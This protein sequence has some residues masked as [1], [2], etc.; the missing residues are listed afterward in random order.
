LHSRE[1]ELRLLGIALARRLDPAALEVELRALARRSDRATR[2]ALA[3][4]LAAAPGPWA[5]QF[6]EHCLTGEIEEELELALLAMLIRR[7]PLQPEHM[8]RVLGARDPTVMA[9]AHVVAKGPGAWPQIEPLVPTPGVASDLVDAIV[10]AGRN[11]CAPLLLACLETAGPEQQHRALVMLNAAARPPHGAPSELLRLLARRGDAAVRAEAVLALSRTMPRSAALRQ[12]VAA[13]D[14]PSFRVRRRA[15]QALC[16]HGERATA[17]LRH[18]LGTVTMASME[19]VWALAAIGSPPARRLLAAYVRELRHDA[20]RAARLREEIAAAPDRARWAAL[21][22]CLRDHHGRIIDVVLAALAPALEARLTRRL[23]HVLQGADQ[24]HRASAFELVAAGPASRLVPG[25]VDLLRYLLFEHSTGAGRLAGSGADNLLDQAGASMS[26]WVRRAAA[27]MAAC[28]SPPRPVLP[29]ARGAGS[30]DR[31]PA[32]ERTMESDDQEFE[33]VVAL[34]RTPLFRYV[35]FETLLEVARSVQ[36][37]LYLT[38]EQV[39]AG[40][41]GGQDLLI[42]EAGVLMVGQGDGA[43]TLTA[44]ACF[45][46]VAVAGEPMRW[47]RITA[48]EDARVSLLRA[49]IFQELCREHP[50]M[51][52]E[53]CRL[54]ARRLRE[55]GAADAH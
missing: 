11:D 2:T 34:K 8:A 45:G 28:P 55:A 23:R 7:T 4:L 18:R 3:P 51:A 14:D 1:P 52:L 6:V 47:P 9:L 48:V 43:R 53:L 37:R 19:V 15:A 33:R 42:L 10:G 20:E 13:L 16:Q 27:L 50:E 26:P 30:A 21:E 5:Q 38:G 12:L 32:G 40:D 22:L 17:L 46:E 39:Q 35:P 49:T 24:R 41:S 31:D 36:A 54:L 25:A 44:P 29:P